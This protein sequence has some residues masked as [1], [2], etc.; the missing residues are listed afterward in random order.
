MSAAA[1]SF[2]T[3]IGAS[4]TPTGA[5][6]PTPARASSDRVAPASDSQ[7]RPYDDF[8]FLTVD[9]C[10]KQLAGVVYTGEELRGYTVNHFQWCAWSDVRVKL[11]NLKGEEINRLY[12]RVTVL[13]S[14][15][16]TDR[17]VTV[18]LYFDDVSWRYGTNF[19]PDTIFLKFTPQCFLNDKGGNCAFRP[20]PSGPMPLSSLSGNVLTYELYSEQTVKG[21]NPYAIMQGTLSLGQFVTTTIPDTL[22][23]AP[24]RYSQVIRC[25]SANLDPVGTKQMHTPACIFPDAQPVLN[26]NINDESIDESAQ[27]I[28]DAQN[29]P[30]AMIPQPEDGSTKTIPNLLTRH[31]DEDLKKDQRNKSVATCLNK[32]G[33][34]PTGTDC[35]EFPFATTMEGSLALPLPNYDYSV[36]YITSRDNQR[37]GCWLG[38]W[39]TKD[40]LL[41]GDKF[42]VHIFDGPVVT[43]EDPVPG[44][45]PVE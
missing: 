33:P 28:R 13:G 19:N 23:I 44:D 18:H 17:S 2:I 9:E 1:I 5:P 21:D 29:N 25:D 37:S 36:R 40:R 20:A 38:K 31:W 7:P 42:T 27:H 6:T 12:Y 26:F 39:Y 16:E 14:G 35:D 15:Q 43:Q 22:P 45:C 34:R 8:K 3:V 24:Q 4:P 11:K 32:I 10:R 41:P 30:A